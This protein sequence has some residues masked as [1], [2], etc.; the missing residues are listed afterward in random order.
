MRAFVHCVSAGAQT[1]QISA[2]CGQFSKSVRA[3]FLLS[4]CHREH[5]QTLCGRCQHCSRCRRL[6]CLSCCCLLPCFLW[7]AWCER[8]SSTASH[9]LSVVAMMSR[10]WQQL[11]HIKL[12]QCGCSCECVISGRPMHGLLRLGLWQHEGLLHREVRSR[13]PMRVP[14]QAQMSDHNARLQGPLLRSEILTHYSAS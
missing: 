9:A 3:L 11:S 14:V 2:R 5:V 13:H 4:T 1:T 8:V 12:T 10:S 7:C 6:R